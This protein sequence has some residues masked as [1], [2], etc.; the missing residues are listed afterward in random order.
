MTGGFSGSDGSEGSEGVDGFDEELPPPP[1]LLPPLLL[2]PG[3]VILG[4]DK[5]WETSTLLK[6]SGLITFTV[7]FP[8]IDNSPILF[9]FTVSISLFSSTV[10]F[11]LCTPFTIIS[12]ILDCASADSRVNTLFFISK[13]FTPAFFIV[14]VNSLLSFSFG[15]GAIEIL[16]TLIF[17]NSNSIFW[18]CSTGSSVCVFCLS[19]PIFNPFSSFVKA[20]EKVPV[21]GFHWIGPLPSPIPAVT[22]PSPA[23]IV[24]TPAFVVISPFNIV[25]ST[26][27]PCNSTLSP[28]PPVTNSTTALFPSNLTFAIPLLTTGTG[29]GETDS[30]TVSS[31]IIDVVP[32]ELLI[33][34]LLSITIDV[35]LSE[36]LILLLSPDKFSSLRIACITSAVPWLISLDANTSLMSL[37]STPIVVFSFVVFSFVV[38]VFSSAV[39]SFVVFVFSSVVFSF[40]VFVFSS[41]VFSFVV[42]VSSFFITF[43]IF[44]RASSERVILVGTFTTS[45]FWVITFICS[46][47]VVTGVSDSALSPVMI[48]FGIDWFTFFV[49]GTSAFIVPTFDVPLRLIETMPW[50]WTFTWICFIVVLG[51]TISVLGLWVPLIV[52]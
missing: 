43:S 14:N 42:F 48:I 39:F 49:T 26:L 21:F 38:F 31:I 13:V 2:P 37:C 47:S 41:V 28:L 40:V 4:F 34:L 22:N 5:R 1:P 50:F 32:S 11:V 33:L 19:A 10:I 9:V 18:L 36:L 29:D 30:K 25:F 35:M 46:I 12:F 27:S 44:S 6:S 20:N 17:S 3:G 24:S 16:S 51:I 7:P 52:S 23:F 8:S 15:S 45:G